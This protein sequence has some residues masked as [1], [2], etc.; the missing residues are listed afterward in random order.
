L[1]AQRLKARKKK[2]RVSPLGAARFPADRRRAP[3]AATR[4]AVR[5]TIF[6]PVGAG[7][8]VALFAGMRRIITSITRALARSS[9]TPLFGRALVGLAVF[10]VLAHIGAGAAAHLPKVE[11]AP[12]ASA[13]GAAV[14]RASAVGSAKPSA[15]P[16][17][18]P[19][20]KGAS[21]G[22]IVVNEADASTFTRLPGVGEK[23]AQAI[24]ALRDKL[25]GRFRRLRDLMRVRGI[26]YRSFKKLEPMIV[27][28]A[29][30]AADDEKPR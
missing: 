22:P 4:S 19:V 29:P 27:L 26:G 11:G 9:W 1:Y 24:V 15:S 14:A 17:P 7:M 25:G 5:R 3:A 10:L 20:S 21:D 30:K 23:R 28:D 12:S 16:C 2:G 6:Q 8:V 13:V 18:K